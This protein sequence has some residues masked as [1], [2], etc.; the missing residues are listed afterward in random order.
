[1]YEILKDSYDRMNVFKDTSI[2]KTSTDIMTYMD[3]IPQQLADV[4]QTLQI[5]LDDTSLQQEIGQFCL[6][7][8]AKEIK[9]DQEKK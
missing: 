9:D 1:M 4:D 5:E 7:N 2:S 3:S 8:E 6:D